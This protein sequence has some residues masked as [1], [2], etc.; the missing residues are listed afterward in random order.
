MSKPWKFIV[1]AI[2]VVL[3]AL[4]SCGVYAIV[5]YRTFSAPSGSMEPTIRVGQVL[6]VD[7]FAY[8]DAQPRRGDVVVFMPPIPSNAPFFKRVVAVPGDR[9]AIRGGRTFLNGKLVH[10]PY[11]PE[12]A[13][14]DLAVRGYDMWVDGVRLDRAIAMIPPRAQWTASDAVPR[15]CYIVLG[16]NRP[17]SQDSHAYGFFCPGQPVPNQPNLHPDLVGRAIVSSR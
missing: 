12:P 9:F 8:R 11:A 7:K 16:D 17:N 13:L 5:R 14:Y 10:E 15:G 2:A 3:V 4:L 1:G 6:V